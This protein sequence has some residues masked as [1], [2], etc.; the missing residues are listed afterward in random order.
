LHMYGRERERGG[1]VGVKSRLVAPASP[2][3]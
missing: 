3:L 1:G 2:R